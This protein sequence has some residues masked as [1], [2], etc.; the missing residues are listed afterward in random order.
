MLKITHLLIIFRNPTP[1]GSKVLWDQYT[2]DNFFKIPTHEDKMET[3]S[4][5][6]LFQFWDNALE[7]V[8]L[9]NYN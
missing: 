3:I 4:T 9:K 7:L 1:E 2:K 6:D 8:N 5:S